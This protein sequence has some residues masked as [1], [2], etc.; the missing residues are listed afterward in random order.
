MKGTVTAGF[1]VTVFLQIFIDRTC[2]GYKTSGFAV[3]SYKL[4]ISLVITDC[5]HTVQKTLNC[6]IIL[7]FSLTD[8]IKSRSHNKGFNCTGR[9]HSLIIDITPRSI[10]QDF[11]LHR[12]G[13]AVAVQHTL[14]FLV[15]TID[16]HICFCTLV[17]FPVNPHIWRN[18]FVFC[19]GTI[20]LKIIT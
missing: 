5:D 15:Q 9:I 2:S 3:I 18:F 20:R 14:Q 16:S 19:Y 4:I 8:L 7:Q 17:P 6:R 1:C 13:A 12:Q 10:F 11:Y